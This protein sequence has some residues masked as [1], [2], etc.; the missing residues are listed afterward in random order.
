MNNKIMTILGVLA[1]VLA[2][3]LNVS[4]ALNDYGVKEN[5]LHVEVLAQTGTTGSGGAGGCTSASGSGT[6]T[7]GENEK[8]WQIGKKTFSYTIKKTNDKGFSW[9]LGVK[10]WAFEGKISSK[11][12]SHSWEETV[13]VEIKCCREMGNEESC[14][15]EKC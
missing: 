9:D 11:T 6:G 15:F 12:P 13:S 5:K 3:G 4:H 8:T 2:I 10:A 1:L 14:S 7:S